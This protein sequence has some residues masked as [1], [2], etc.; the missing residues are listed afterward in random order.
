MLIYSIIVTYNGMNNNWIKKC[1]E[2]LLNS[3]VKT[4]IVVIDNNSS[5]ETVIFIKENYPEIILIEQKVN[6]GFGQANNLGLNIGLKNNADFYFLLN[7][8]AW[9]TSE[10][11]SN[12][13]NELQKDSSFGLVSPIHLDGDGANLDLSFSNYIVPKNCKTFYSDSVLCNYRKKIYDCTFVNAACWLLSKKCI[14]TVGGFSPSF[15]HYGEDDNYSHRLHFHS[16]KLGIVPNTFIFHDRAKR[17]SNKY[18][19]DRLIV[20]KRK[21]IL[22]ASNP[23]SNFSWKKE[24]ILLFKDLTKSILLLNFTFTR[25]VLNKNKV[26]RN[27]NRTE[28][29]IN[30]IQSKFKKASFLSNE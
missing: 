16:L 25:F 15:F 7:Q 9:V 22:E 23:K 13:I 19:D 29:S 5:D 24:Q 4:N 30:K 28:I 10:T 12:L 1:L 3:N 17:L 2:S 8:D 6:I 21:I 14:E 20:Y 27:I 26:L 18:F 11:I